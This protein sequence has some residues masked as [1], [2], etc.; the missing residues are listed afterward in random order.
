MVQSLELGETQHTHILTRPLTYARS[1]HCAWGLAVIGRQCRIDWILYDW[2]RA[3]MF[4]NGSGLNLESVTPPRN[5]HVDVWNMIRYMNVMWSE[6]PFISL[7]LW[8]TPCVVAAWGWGVLLLLLFSTLGTVRGLF[9]YFFALIFLLLWIFF[10]L[11]FLF[12]C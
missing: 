6:L 9:V 2:T 3:D 4:F 5:K 12:R 8:T 11:T 7:S 10:A 1:S